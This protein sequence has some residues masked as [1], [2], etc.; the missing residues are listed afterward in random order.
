MVRRTAFTLIELL[1]SIALGMVLIALGT[2][3]MLHVSKA[4]NRNI[5]MLQARDDVGAIHQRLN[6]SFSAMYH[7]SLIYART[8]P[9]EVAPAAPVWGDGNESIE[10][11]WMSSLSDLE[12]RSM[13]MEPPHY[14]DLV[15][16][17]LRWQGRGV[18][19]EGGTLSYA[20][21]SQSRTSS[22]IGITYKN[23]SGAWVNGSATV[24]IGPQPRRDRRR[25]QNDN[26]LR[27]LP[28][29][30]PAVY[31][32]LGLIGDDTDLN[33]RLR[34]M[35]PSRT[36]VA[37]FSLE[38]T[39]LD[40]WTTRCDP[41]TGITIRRPDGTIQPPLG[42][43]YANGQGLALDGTWIDGRRAI[44]AGDTRTVLGQRPVLIA[45]TFDL[46]P[47]LDND[48]VDLSREARIPFVLTFRAAP[49]LPK[50]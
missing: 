31:A 41:V 42:L 17:R 50:L 8:D 16:N 33:L 28:G 6:A 25:N 1:V 29:I 27:Y 22:S 18:G 13:D 11:T 26:D 19:K 46:I 5:V 21:S 3:A 44:A 45:I 10:F 20:V 30:T 12:E 9:G 47:C 24:R 36:R 7:A 15:W 14:S 49:M 48:P 37:R 34:P 38:W 32:E 2:S 23:D 4:F 40:G 35:H 43:P 39:D